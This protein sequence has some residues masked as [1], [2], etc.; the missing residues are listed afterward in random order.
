MLLRL[1]K[2]RT[3]PALVFALLAFSF[4]G[5]SPQAKIAR[6]L[7]NADHNYLEGR[8]DEAEIGYK[9][10]LRLQGE[11]PRAIAQLALLYS[12]QGR[13]GYAIPF[14]LKGRELQ[15][16]NMDLRIRY[17]QL[18][19]A[20]G[21]GKDARTEAAYVL[22]RRPD[23]ADA[24]LLLAATISR[25]EDVNTVLALFETLPQPAREGPA[26]L[27]ALGQIELGR[28]RLPEAE[29][30]FT[31]ALRADG[32]FAMAH[33]GMAS[34]H[35]R[36]KDAANTEKSL[37]AATEHAPQRSPVRL[38]YARY[39]FQTGDAAAAKDMLE[40]MVAATPDFVPART[41]L[42][43]IALQEK[44]YAECA[45]QLDQ[46]AKRDPANSDAMLLRGRLQLAQGEP[47]KA[48]ESFERLANAYPKAS[49][50]HFQ[51]GLAHLAANETAKAAASFKQALLL[52]PT[53]AEA[54]IA[55]ATVQLRTGDPRSAVGVLKPLLSKR[56]DL[57]QVRFLLADAYR[58]QNNLAEALAVYD[59]LEKDYPG[60]PQ[61]PLL[62]GNTLL[63]AKQTAQAREAFNEALK[64][65]PGA[66]PALD[67]LVAID[68][69]ERKFEA[70]SQRTAAALA[71]NPDSAGLLV[72]HARVCIV[73]A[74]TAAAEA[75]L[76]K[77]TALHPE[78]ITAYY[79]LAQ[80]HLAANSPELALKKLQAG[81][82]RSPKDV[83][84]WM[85]LALVHEQQ[86]DYAR[87][88]DAYE[89]AIA[90]NPRFASALNNVA[91]LYSERL[92]DPDKGL[93]AAL[94]ARE[95]QPHEPHIA[96]TLGW[97]LSKK[98][99]QRRALSLLEE[100]ASKLQD[101][102]E[103]HYHA[104]VARYMLGQED[105]A[106]ASLQRS[107][108]LGGGFV[109]AD[110]AKQRMAVL[111][112]KPESADGAARA[113]LA[114][115]LQD[116]PSDPVALSRQADLHE[117][118][119]A[120]EKAIATHLI[121][122]GANAETATPLINV[123]R[124]HAA[125]GETAKALQYAKAARKVE[126][127]SPEIARVLGR[128]SY[129]ASD[130]AWA[131]SLLTDAARNVTGEPDALF[132]AA[133]ALYSIGRVSD[134]IDSAQA[135]LD[136]AATA[137]TDDSN[138][139]QTPFTRLTEAK[140]F[141]EMTRLASH[142][143]ASA[144]ERLQKQ[145]KNQANNVPTLM[146]LGA[147]HEAK[148][149]SAAAESLYARALERFPD[150]TPAKVRLAILG[151]SKAV[152]DEKAYGLAL[153]AREALPNDA[154]VAKA[155]GILTYRKANDPR[156]AIA[157]LKQSASARADDAESVFFL[158]LAQI[159]AKDSSAAR[160]SLER[161]LTMGLKGPHADE[162]RKV[163]TTAK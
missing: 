125:R 63:Q 153:Q 8:Y 102:A 6:H 56:P 52:S 76:N 144:E 7:K 110:D 68:L 49:Q 11:N 21:A 105:A 86:K 111:D 17:A 57:P 146:A 29:A 59:Q 4:G 87:A 152:F 157:L 108:E 120:L 45:N 134:A 51:L 67:R 143:D 43:E 38:Q 91:V 46:L 79:L 5:C 158:G 81:I 104:G 124:L 148:A 70:A 65:A 161:A 137:Q 75:A 98:G 113:F 36:R 27:T 145:L 33:A 72:L 42:A 39:V 14:V 156:R 77:A 151:S 60:H 103:I 135:A 149:E 74:D 83:G 89:Q 119:G 16:D 78:E 118:D 61:T 106:R 41:L 94:K 154:E 50:A 139:P 150:F 1:S 20:I 73:R 80:L 23:D 122:A 25:V 127:D 10:V 163:L 128:I 37:R 31:R 115:R 130:F 132:E 90:L 140:L 101:S 48:V 13:V 126:P 2:H 3:L 131:A 96:D 26:V 24:P 93:A 121:S 147:V 44:Q 133:E 160:A 141:L 155:L 19:V 109:G 107:I 71:Q 136:A 100:S 129:Q 142:P 162:A 123:A 116:S 64:R 54:G 18:S 112:F 82:S 117:K 40:K 99:Q 58:A 62:K 66:L 88:R 159:Q 30:F 35:V 22:A 28:G 85:L 92:N 69:Q 32:R 53:L 84:A 12:D 114:K 15:P 34:L 9:N 97:I 138:R 47:A 95:L 55:L